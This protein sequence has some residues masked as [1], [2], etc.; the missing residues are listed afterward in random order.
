METGKLKCEWC[1]KNMKKQNKKKHDGVCLWKKEVKI[2]KKDLKK[3]IR[4]QG[5]I[6]EVDEDQARI[7]ELSYLELTRYLKNVYNNSIY[8][9]KKI[10]VGAQRDPVE[11]LREMQVSDVTKENYVREWKLYQKW[12]KGNNEVINKDTANT[13]LAS[14]ENRR[15]S[16]IRTKHSL[17]ENIF[18][19]LLDPTVSLNKFNRRISFTPKYVMKDEELIPYQEEQRGINFEDYLI[20][21]LL[22]RYGLRINSI[23]S[24]K[25]KHL[26]F[27]D[28][29]CEKTIHFPD[30]KVK[31]ERYEPVD[32]ELGGE[33]REF[34]SRFIDEIDNDDEFVFDRNRSE[35][36]ERKRAHDLSVRINNR[37]RSS[38]IIKMNR[39]YQYSSHMFR[40]TRVYNEYQEG[41]EKLKEDLRKKIGQAKGSTSLN[42]YINANI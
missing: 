34:V 3:L 42:S 36:P 33:I 6:V 35:V 8:L 29:G 11:R 1:G 24:L 4:N 31:R 22:M 30:S 40:K 41:V 20:Q 37:I 18:K 9:Y 26:V 21:K 32:D 15:A 5:G 7:K 25:I 16:T 39:N 10:I 13:Y 23:A 14:L 19:F 12:L 2:K 17:L 38:K 27:L 28:E